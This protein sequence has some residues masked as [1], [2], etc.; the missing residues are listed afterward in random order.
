LYQKHYFYSRILAIKIEIYKNLFPF[1]KEM[2]K[3]WYGNFIGRT[4]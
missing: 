3:F 1:K 2:L 4:L